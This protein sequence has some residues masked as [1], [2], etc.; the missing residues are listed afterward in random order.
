MFGGNEDRECEFGRES[1][2]FGARDASASENEAGEWRRGRSG[3]VAESE[4]SMRLG[5]RGIA[6]VS[7]IKFEPPPPE[8]LVGE[9]GDAAFEAGSASFGALLLWLT[10]RDVLGLVMSKLESRP[11]LKAFCSDCLRKASK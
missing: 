1:A 3:K 8:F 10:D 11:R 7:A 5:E 6:S 9:T 4:E 2:W